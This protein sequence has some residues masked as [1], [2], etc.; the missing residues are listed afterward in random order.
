MQDGS[1]QYVE[2][3]EAVEAVAVEAVAVLKAAKKIPTEDHDSV[4]CALCV[5]RGRKKYAG[6]HSMLTCF[7]Y[8][9]G[10]YFEPVFGYDADGNKKGTE[11]AKRA[12]EKRKKTLP[13]FTERKKGKGSGGSSGSGKRSYSEAELETLFEEKVKK[14]KADKEKVKSSPEYADAPADVVDAMDRDEV[15]GVIGHEVAHVANGDMVTMTLV[16]GVV[17]AFVMFFSSD[18]KS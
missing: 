8:P 12:W 6:G 1:V 13:G 7:D 10:D 14:L 15:E 11:A 9:D 4:P 16:Q 5:A 17:N 2:A 18:F 3:V